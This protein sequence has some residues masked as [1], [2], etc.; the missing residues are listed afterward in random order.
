MA[1]RKGVTS[2]QGQK[3]FG[4]ELNFV[5]NILITAYCCFLRVLKYYVGPEKE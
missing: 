1:G 3:V 5:S 4:K 2:G